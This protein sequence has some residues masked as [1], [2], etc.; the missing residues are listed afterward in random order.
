[1]KCCLPIRMILIF[2]CL[3]SAFV[4]CVEPESTENVKAGIPAGDYLGQQP[5]GLEPKVFAPGIV[6]TGLSERDFAITRD[7]NE[8]YF[9]ASVG[10]FK[11][12]TMLYTRRTGG[13]WEPP[14]VVPFASRYLDFEP[15]LAPDDSRM[16]FLSTRPLP[17][18]E[19]PGDQDI[20]VVDRQET[21]WGEPYN[22]GP[23]VNTEAPEFFPSI[24]NDLTLYFTREEAPGVEAI[25]RSRFVDG[26]YQEAERLPEQVNCGTTRYN[27]FVS[28]DESFV[29]VPAAGREDCFGG[30][31]YYI[32]FRTGDDQWSEPVH[33]DERINSATGR[34]WSPFV[35]PDGKYFFFMSSRSFLDQPD[36]PWPSTGSDLVALHNEP[37]N[38]NSD[39]WWVSAEI[40]DEFRAKA[41]WK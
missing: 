30:T 40:L 25:Y 28:R 26:K 41:V 39:I 37:Q 14:R 36:S 3:L 38:G 34:E 7:G 18:Q 29:I 6:S 24:T 22:L 23:P 31:D 33:M 32:T 27:A 5:P 20:W 16:F 13:R 1:M 17:G 19:R 21:G 12:S 10:S 35:T 11:V 15:C 2:A 9:C 8:I 4:G